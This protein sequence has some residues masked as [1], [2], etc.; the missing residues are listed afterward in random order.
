MYAKQRKLLA[1]SG[2]T[3]GGSRRQREANNLPDDVEV[4]TV[5]GFQGREKDIIILDTVRSNS[6]GQIGFLK[7]IVQEIYTA[8]SAHPHIAVFTFLCQSQGCAY[9]TYVS[10]VC[11]ASTHAASPSADSASSL[12]RL[13]AFTIITSASTRSTTSPMRLP[14]CFMLP[15]EVVQLSNCF[16]LMKQDE[17]RLNVAITRAR[18]LL[19]II[20][21]ASTLQN[22]GSKPWM[23]L[24]AHAREVGAL[25]SPGQPCPS[26]PEGETMSHQPDS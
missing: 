1:S 12:L 13:Q 6:S 21:N 3:G 19:I 23:S 24:V 17:R 7:V 5:D 16:P 8:A 25:V 9:V 10:P 14:R 26:P 11:H 4:K 18:R 20:G 2:G 15:Y 22:S